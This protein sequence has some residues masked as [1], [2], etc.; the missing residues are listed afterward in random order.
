MEL[1][2][3]ILKIFLGVLF[4][5][6]GIMHIIKPQF[7]KHFTPNFLP[8][9]L[10][11]YVFGTIEFFV[12]LGLFFTATAKI[13]AMGVFLLLVIF[14]PIHIWDFTKARPAIGSK[15]LAIVRIPFQFLLAYFA[16]LIYIN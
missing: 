5:F 7:F 14:L 3:L 12:G 8:K 1:F 6:A 10:V 9:L 13:A 2:V 15:R 4:C 16:Y 11:N